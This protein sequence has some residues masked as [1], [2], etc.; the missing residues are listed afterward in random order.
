M[1]LKPK[2]SLGQNFLT[3][4]NVQNKIIG[5]CALHKED[6]VLEI[7]AGKGDMTR[8]LAEEAGKVYSIEIDKGL[9]PVLEENLK[10]FPNCVIL[11]KDI[12]K[13]D[14]NRFRE[15]CSPQRKIKVVGNIPYYISTPI[16]ERLIACRGAVDSAFITVQK[17]FAR[18]VCA[19]AG[20]KDYGSFSC[21][22]RYYAQTCILFEIKRGSFVPVPGVDSSLLKFVFR[23]VPPV[24]VEQEDKLFKLIRGAFGQRRKTLKN[25]LSGLV[26]P[27][28]LEDF[29]A[30]EGI[31][32]RARAEELTL[33]NFA[34][35]GR[36]AGFC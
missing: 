4:K 29:L 28:V 2:K 3:D 18:R 23:T 17:E 36:Y 35:L 34:G 27:V 33:E 31:D 10:D 20:S 30:R 15:E 24:K 13:F 26:D 1:R 6:V 12:L 16:I 8:R 25:S 11:N 32:R 5:A 21:F 7:G 19:G 9:I 22:V 14:I